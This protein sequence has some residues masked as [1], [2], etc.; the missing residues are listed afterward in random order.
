MI[1]PITYFQLMF[2][3]IAAVLVVWGVYARSVGERFVQWLAAFGALVLIALVALF[4]GLSA[5]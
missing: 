4:R 2:A 1:D 5:G 3:A